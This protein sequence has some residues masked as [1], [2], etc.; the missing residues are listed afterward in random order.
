[1]RILISERQYK[2]IREFYENPYT[3]IIINIE[4]EI[5]DTISQY[6]LEV[7]KISFD[8][9]GNYYDIKRFNS[10][11]DEVGNKIKEILFERFGNY[12]SIKND[13]FKKVVDDNVISGENDFSLLGI[14]IYGYTTEE[15]KHKKSQIT[16]L[17]FDVNE[18][19]R[20][21]L[22]KFLEVLK[23]QFP[24]QWQKVNKKIEVSDIE[25]TPFTPSSE[26]SKGDV[27]DGLEQR[28]YNWEYTKQLLERLLLKYIH[29]EQYVD[30][31]SFKY[32]NKNLIF[33]KAF[34][35]MDGVMEQNDYKTFGTIDRMNLKNDLY[36][37]VEEFKTQFNFPRNSKYRPY[38]VFIDLVIG[39]RDKTKF[40]LKK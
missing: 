30:E 24:Q 10:I 28:I 36:R 17:K 13:E 16:K 15:I 22:V 33:Y 3:D 38:N 2:L 32:I 31:E 11:L 8:L 19:M 35:L 14:K 34:K 12:F 27:D 9:D 29:M 4:K 5:K 20:E 6:N 39:M 23:K 25:I 21:A 7:E 40:E 37:F 26:T 1:M 18:N